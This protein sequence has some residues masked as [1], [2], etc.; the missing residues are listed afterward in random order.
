MSGYVDNKI[1]LIIENN[2]CLTIY[3]LAD[4]IL[5]EVSLIIRHCHGED[6]DFYEKRKKYYLSLLD[7][8]SSVLVRTDQYEI[9]ENQILID[10]PDIIKLQL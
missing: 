1:N 2:Y 9:I 3:A 6:K 7:E 5:G 4:S 10:N 8:Q